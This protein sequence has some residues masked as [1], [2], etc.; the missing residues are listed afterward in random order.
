MARDTER[1]GESPHENDIGH[2]VHDKC[3][4]ATSK[5][6]DTE[7]LIHEDHGNCDGCS[8]LN[9]GI[10]EDGRVAHVPAHEG[11]VSDGQTMKKNVDVLKNGQRAHDDFVHGIHEAGRVAH[12]VANGGRGSTKETTNPSTVADD[13]GNEPHG[14]A[15][16]HEKNCD[17]CSYLGHGTHE[18]GRVAHV[19]AHEGRG[20]CEETKKTLNTEV[21]GME[22]DLHTFARKHAEHC[23]GCSTMGAETHEDGRVAHVPAH[24]GHEQEK[25]SMPVGTNDDPV[26]T[27]PRKAILKMDSGRLLMLRTALKRAKSKKNMARGHG[28]R[29]P[30]CPKSDLVGGIARKTSG[31]SARLRAR[32]LR[33][34]LFRRQEEGARSVL[35]SKGGP[36][37]YHTFMAS[38]TC[39]P[40]GPSGSD[41]RGT[42]PDRRRPRGQ[43][44]SASGC[45]R[46]ADDP[47]SQDGNA[48]TTAKRRRISHERDENPGCS[49]DGMHEVY[50]HTQQLAWER[51]AAGDQPRGDNIG[52]LLN[53]YAPYGE[54]LKAALD[55]DVIQIAFKNYA[56]EEFLVTMRESMQEDI[57]EKRRK[58]IERI[59]KIAERLS[60][61]KRKLDDQLEEGHPAKGLH[62][63]LL[64][65][66]AMKHKY[67][68]VSV[69][70][71]IAEGMRVTGEIPTSKILAP[72]ATLATATNDDLSSKRRK[73]N[74]RVCKW[75]LDHADDHEL[76]EAIWSKT[77][78]EAE[79]GWLTAPTPLTRGDMN[80]EFISPRFA[81]RQR[82]GKLR[83]IDNF[84]MSHVNTLAGMH[85]TYCP[86]GINHM[87]CSARALHG[88]GARELLIYT[89]DIRNAFKTI[90]L[91]VDDQKFATIA[92]VNPSSGTIYK[93]T[94]KVLPFGARASPLS[95]GRV[96]TFLQFL[97]RKALHVHTGAYVDD[98]HAI[99]AEGSCDSGFEV[100]KRFLDIT[101]FAAESKK[102]QKPTA[103]AELL[104]ATISP[105]KDEVIVQADQE[106]I[107]SLL[108]SIQTILDENRLTSGD[109]AKLRG[110]LSFMCSLAYGR[111]GR[112]AMGELMARQYSKNKDT[113]LG[114]WLKDDLIWWK[115]ILPRLPPRAMSLGDTVKCC[116][117]TDAQGHG[118]LGAYVALGSKAWYVS[119]VAPEWATERYGIFEFELLAALLGVT[120]AVERIAP[121][122]IIL[123]VD[124]EGAH[125][126]IMKGNC[127]TLMARHISQAIWWTAATGTH[128]RSTLLWVEYIHTD[129]NIADFPSR[130]EKCNDAHD[131][132]SHSGGDDSFQKWCRER[133]VCIPER[134]ETPRSFRDMTSSEASVRSAARG[135]GRLSST[136]D[137]T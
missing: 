40:E 118:Q 76:V 95:W 1:W 93:C 79:R 28:N 84:K 60:D 109:A 15:R 108:E 92:T 121:G 45:G 136:G 135:R 71:D 103:E 133:D 98:I 49:H 119:T 89:L 117:Y 4:G 68:D 75:L 64:R 62:I 81:V 11:R 102:C 120:I 97:L 116:V 113:S 8:S 22:D 46:Q 2:G 50:D 25:I 37:C 9:Y 65:H 124:N 47:S 19:P 12:G 110:R 82:H 67:P 99:E 123:F 34:S 5:Q 91:H 36:G 111:I 33:L 59:E 55:L 35:T 114:P 94:S 63:P 30:G 23:D 104:G 52:R 51:A 77:A 73:R 27:I 21:H 134:M 87:L 101:G 24:D 39:A 137:D 13:T 61:E 74:T 106:R 10:H 69:T 88:M 100:T 107:D 3:P 54:H 130:M 105:R 83:L 16:E 29:A 41:I 129:S 17:G 56:K 90:P 44:P 42:T 127:Q 125:Y 86:Q 78:A 80:T 7:I 32:F 72:K 38:P 85:E 14:Y 57:S 53:P 6:P 128:P 66:L 48:T 26:R 126:S 43:D 70:K 112:G 96:I 20:S 31:R 115:A 58:A 131:G 122:C 18:V 132:T